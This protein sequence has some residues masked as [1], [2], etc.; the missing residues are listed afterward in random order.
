MADLCFI[1]NESLSQGDPVNVVRGLKT[2]RVASIERNDGYI[3]FLNS[4]TSVNVHTE[5]RKVH[6]SKNSIAA[7]KRRIE[8]SEPLSSPSYDLIASEAKYHTLCYTNF[9]NP[10]PSTEKKSRQDN[11][12]S[13]AIA[14]IF[15]YIENHDDSQFTLKELVDV[16]TGR[17]GS[18]RLIDVLYRLRFAA[19]YGKIVQ[20][21]ISAVYHPQFRILS[22]ESG[23]L[24][25]YVGDNA[26]INVH[27]L[28]GNNAL[29]V[30]GMIKIVTPKDAVPL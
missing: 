29:H 6:I 4:S 11:Q 13:E 20:Y 14:E 15:N 22:S 9:L 16:L 1:C 5:C 18:K 7:S 19:S 8:N 25:Q 12:V 3:N 23:T 27:S 17:Y 2:L 30:M 10:L 26:N 24:V 28:D 21:E